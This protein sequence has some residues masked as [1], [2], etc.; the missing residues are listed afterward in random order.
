MQ[1]LRLNKEQ[2]DVLREVGTIGGGSA[3][4]ALSQILGKKVTIAVPQ[5]KILAS[6][7]VSDSEFFIGPGEMSLVVDLNILGALQG[8]MIVLFSRKSAL[9]M[10]DILLKRPT[11]STQLL[12]VLEASA[13]SESAHI[14]SGSYLNAVGEL[15]GL[16]RLIPSIPQ[17]VVDRMDTLNKLII[18]KFSDQ[19]F[20]YLMPIENELTIEDIKVQLYVVFF[21]EYDS[22]KKILKVIGL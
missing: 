16:H 4:T 13:I 3:A 11:G 2:L 21:L 18:K 19:N 14:L 6:D 8:G 5:V 22:V 7:K 9:L 15:L 20:R 12:N 17:T 1:N 10:I